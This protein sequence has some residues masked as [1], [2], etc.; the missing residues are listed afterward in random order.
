MY[1]ITVL[2]AQHA[3]PGRLDIGESDEKTARHFR[4]CADVSLICQHAGSDRG[5]KD[6]R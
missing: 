6:W 5:I 3:L 4:L 1:R 2:F